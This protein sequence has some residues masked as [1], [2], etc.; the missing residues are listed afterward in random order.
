VPSVRPV[1]DCA[2][3]RP[4]RHGY[5]RAYAHDRNTRESNRGVSRGS[6]GDRGESQSVPVQVIDHRFCV[7]VHF[8][9]EPP[10]RDL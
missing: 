1:P 5:S 3:P 6:V 2:A 10:W 7:T 4:W 9:S 8:T